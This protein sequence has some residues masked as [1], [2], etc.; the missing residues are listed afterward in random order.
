MCLLTG[1][2]CDVAKSAW[3]KSRE[4]RIV[5]D[6]LLR[7]GH[8]SAAVKLADSSG[9]EVVCVSVRARVCALP[10]PHLQQLVDTEVFL[11][12][13]GVEEGLKRHDTGESVVHT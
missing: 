13:Q 6:H 8:Y 7:Q 10:S 3:Q 4:D 11:V 5:V 2:Q 1:D 12:C 9:I